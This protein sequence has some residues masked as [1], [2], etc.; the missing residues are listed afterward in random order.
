M[1]NRWK[2]FGSIG[3]NVVIKGFQA[4]TCLPQ[5]RRLQWPVLEKTG[6]LNLT[7]DRS[8]FDNNVLFRYCCLRI[9]CAFRPCIETIFLYNWILIVRRTNTLKSL[10]TFYL[11]FWIPFLERTM[12]FLNFNRRKTRNH[13]KLF[14]YINC[15]NVTKLIINIFTPYLQ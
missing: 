7:R 13:W 10:T 9:L 8:L 11:K 5:L 15:E 4:D 3:W 12:L 6:E 2:C 1:D 14:T